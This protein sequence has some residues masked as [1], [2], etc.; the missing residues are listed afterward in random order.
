M[1]EDSDWPL[2]V[3]FK[4][5]NFLLIDFVYYGYRNNPNSTIRKPRINTYRDNIIGLISISD[6]LEEMANKGIVSTDLLQKCK[7]RVFQSILSLIMLSRDYPVNK[8]LNCIKL[9]NSHK[10]IYNL[11]KYKL[12]NTDKIKLLCMKYCPVVLILPIRFLTLIKRFFSIKY[13]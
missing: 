11:C 4:C 7:L 3:Y 12:K 8:S 5:D 2:K 13:R 1:Y 10:I 6:F 9:L